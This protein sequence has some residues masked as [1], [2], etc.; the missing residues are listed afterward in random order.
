MNGW[1]KTTA[2]LAL[3][4]AVVVAHADEYDDISPYLGVDFKQAYMKGQGGWKPIFP[5]TYPGASFYVGTKFHQYFGLE[6]GYDWSVKQKKEWNLPAGS[7]FFGSTAQGT[8]GTTKIER[9]GAYLDLVGFLPVADCLEIMGSTGLGW[10]QTKIESNFSTTTTP[11]SGALASVAGKGRMVFRVG[12]GALYMITD[13]VGVRAKMGFE[14]T[15][16]LKLVGNQAFS[17]YGYN[18]KGFKGTT[19]FA[20][21]AFFKF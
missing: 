9:N 3:T 2:T 7:S 20:V 5:N 4:M 16:A 11:E 1:Q 21:G 6:L 18:E 10:V 19:A 14:G 13:V 17:T 12:I 15:S 8:S